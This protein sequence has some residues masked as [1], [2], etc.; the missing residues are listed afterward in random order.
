MERKQEMST[1]LDRK[2]FKTDS[3]FQGFSKL[4]PKMQ[5]VAK[6]AVD[7][8]ILL[9]VENPV[10][11]ETVTTKEI[12]K[13]L[14]RVS[15]SHQQGRAIDLRTW[16]M[17]EA[18]LIKLFNLLSV[19]YS[20]IGAWTK[21]GIRQLIVHHDSGHGDHFHIQLDRSFALEI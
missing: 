19:H 3:A 14:G 2:H 20:S 7:Q 1:T 6:F 8:A 11:T 16:N 15:V 12:D 13:A 10:I 21:T 5:E 4:H 17:N 9:G 18:Q